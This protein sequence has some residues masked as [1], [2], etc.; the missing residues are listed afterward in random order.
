MY[1]HKYFEGVISSSRAFPS[2]MGW[3]CCRRRADD[4]KEEVGL[5][6]PQCPQGASPGGSIYQRE[7]ATGILRRQ[8]RTSSEEL[9]R[10]RDEL[11]ASRDSAPL[12]P[13]SPGWWP[14]KGRRQD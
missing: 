8:V 10:F 13:D 7:Q 1:R 12:V 11:S 14:R 5:P 6:A 9:D 4:E 3:G 2:L